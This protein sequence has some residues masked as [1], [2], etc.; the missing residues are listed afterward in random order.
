MLDFEVRRKLRRLLGEPAPL[1]PEH[2][3]ELEG[4]LMAAFGQ[5]Y[6]EQEVVPMKRLWLRK[7]LVVAAAAVVCGAAACVAPADVEVPVGRSISI[8]VADG[9]ELPEPEALMAAVRGEGKTARRARVMVRGR[10]GDGATTLTLDVWG[11]E[12]P[13]GDVAERIRAAFPALAGAE[14]REDVLAGTVRG[15]LGAKLGHELLDLDVLD[16][17]DVEAARRQV[18]EQL[19]AQGVEGKVDVQIEGDGE[20]RKVKVQI[21][22]EAPPQDEA[23]MAPPP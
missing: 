6:P 10:R 8:E 15:T 1:R 16:K 17:D 21:K 18:M 3:R 12:V 22:L 4:E 14:I 11:D 5:L 2:A 13:E 23:E 20:K 7:A 19:A 9:A